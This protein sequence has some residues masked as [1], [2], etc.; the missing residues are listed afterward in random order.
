MT[1]RAQLGRVF[2]VLLLVIGV[3]ATS[4]VA[5]AAEGAAS[6]TGPCATPRAATDTLFKWQLPGR[7]DF[8]RAAECLEKGS[9]SEAELEELARMTR[10][11]YDAHGAWV[12]MDELPNDPDY[13]DDELVSQVVPHKALPDI[14]V[15]KRGDRWLWTDASLERVEAYYSE[16]GALI[17]I[18]NR[19]PAFFHEVRVLDVALWQYL[20]LVLL[21]VLGIL[22]RTILAAVVAS[23]IKKLT[24]HLKTEWPKTIVDVVASPGATLLTAVV[25]RIGYPQ[26]LLP[27]SWSQALAITVQVLITI[28]ILWAVYRGVDV[29][30]ARLAERADKTDSK[31]D[32]QL[33][34]LLRKTLKVVVFIVGTLVVL[35]NLKF[36]VTTLF[37]SVSIGGLAIGLAAKDTLANLFGSISIFV[38]SPFQIGDWINVGGKD[39]T[40]EEVGFRSTRIR[41]FYNSVLVMPNAT[42]A[43]ANIDNYGLRQYRRCFITLGLTYDT[44]PE[45]MQAFI[46]GCRAIIQAN[47]T[48]RKDAYEVHMSGFGDSA[49]EV[50]LYFFFE[51]AT[52]TEELEARSNLFLEIMRLA[53]DLGVSFAFPTQSLHLESMAPAAAR[54]APPLLSLEELRDVVRGYGPDGDRGRP[55]GVKI[56][57][58]QYTAATRSNRGESGEG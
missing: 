17:R 46:E 9:R 23:R 42:L 8:A 52:W 56:T 26:L 38:D 5:R 15:A 58:S 7:R 40:V 14:V 49:L 53:R 48:T 31:L 44:T 57:S 6:A 39:G 22:V 20:A 55:S 47:P 50:M 24:A 51:C 32:D 3:I 43:N 21:V 1:R 27:V 29:L 11:V 54:D 16:V 25:L 12:V 30:C 45:Q 37:A 19:L 28:S 13:H 4:A 41:T 36:D 33:I 18:A 10:T 35:Q 2:M 34:P